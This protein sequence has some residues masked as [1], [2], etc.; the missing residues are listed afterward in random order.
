MQDIQQMLQLDDV[1]VVAG[2]LTFQIGANQNQN[3]SLN[4]RNMKQMV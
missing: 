1:E 4:I 3:L 2:S